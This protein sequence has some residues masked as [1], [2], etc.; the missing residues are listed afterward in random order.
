MAQLDAMA[1]SWAMAEMR[2]RYQAYVLVP[3]FPIRSA[4][5]G[6][7]SPEQFAEPSSAL[8]DVQELI[9]SFASTHAVDTSRIYATGFSMGG[10][11]AWLLPQRS[12]NTF[13]A[14]V[15]ISGIAPSNSD[16]SSYLNV[17]I[18]AMHGNADNENPITADK[19]FIKAIAYFGG[20]KA[21]LFEYQGLGHLPP[22]DAYPGYWWR[23]WL[24]K[25]Q[26][27]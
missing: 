24:F 15:P 6:S 19:R 8:D 11:A 3:Q 7:A 13:A 22:A 12:P 23:D 20:T 27:Q 21:R 9:T 5:Y 26:R 16:A 14:I 4:N 18:L 10:S 17:P 2:S 25:Q 1:K